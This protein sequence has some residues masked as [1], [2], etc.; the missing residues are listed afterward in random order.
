[1]NVN[2]IYIPRIACQEGLS[3]SIGLK[4]RG[5]NHRRNLRV[6]PGYSACPAVIR[7]DW[8]VMIRTV[9]SA[10]IVG[11]IACS[12]VATS[13]VA[14]WQY[15]KWGM[16]PEQV[17]KASK[18]AARANSDRTLDAPNGGL[19]AK[20]VA[21]YRAGGFDFRAGFMFSP[22]DRLKVVD[23]VLQSGSCPSLVGALTSTYGPQ[24]SADHSSLL[25]L[26]TW[27]DKKNGNRVV[28]GEVGSDSCSVQ[29]SPLHVPGKPGGL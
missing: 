9:I 28:L 18:G 26:D 21:P 15:T 14:D 8:G 22:D 10:F 24:Q 29:Y 12:L 4:L 1:V 5:A 17:V 2:N 20:L 27:W 6:Q 23:L 25:H 11:V 7:R 16:T 19:V 13:A 3:I